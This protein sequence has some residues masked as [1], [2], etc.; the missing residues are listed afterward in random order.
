[1]TNNKEEKDKSTVS[2]IIGWVTKHQLLCIVIILVIGICFISSY[3]V[4]DWQVL[5][6]IA[7]WILAAGVVVAIL[8]LSD[9]R[10]HADKQAEEA[11]KSTNAQLA[12]E[13]F[14]VLRSKETK[15]TLRFIYQLDQQNIKKLSKTKLKQIDGV[16]DQLELLGVLVNQGIIEKSL[17]IEA[18]AGAPA[19]RCWYQLA[20]YI[21][22]QEKI[23]GFYVL[24]Y[25]VFVRCTIEYFEEE[26]I[27]LN[28][29]RIGEKDIPLVS[30]FREQIK[31]NNNLR[32]RKLEEI[33]S[34][35]RKQ[36]QSNKVK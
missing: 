27:D 14:H 19:L 8:Q 18:F 28:Y 36:E 9:N 15:D 5:G 4:W 10:Y 31:N 11:R 20:S 1:M 3:R 17:A 34:E 24:N 13:L 35:R 16:I 33:R 30:Y 25:E 23:R 29:F 2:K 7:T 32:P 22:K 21:R 6:A 12:V 26:H